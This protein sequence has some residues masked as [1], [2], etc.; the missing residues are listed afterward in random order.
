VDKEKKAKL[1]SWWGKRDRELRDSIPMPNDQLRD[2]FAFL[3]REA[4]P[5]CD[6]TLRETISFLRGRNLDIEEIIP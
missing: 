4:A 5:P 1:K 3:D 6:H 2:L